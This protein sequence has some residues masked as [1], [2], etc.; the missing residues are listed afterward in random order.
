MKPQGTV[1]HI[2][3]DESRQTQDRFMLLGGLI[4]LA[5]DENAMQERFRHF[6]Q[7]WKMFAELKWTKV[8][9]QKLAEYKAFVDIFFDVFEA[10][11]AHFTQWH[12]TRTR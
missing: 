10:G 7:Q 2:Y 4:L 3:C 5:G 12:W 11:S 1:Y 9:G 8:S 6:R